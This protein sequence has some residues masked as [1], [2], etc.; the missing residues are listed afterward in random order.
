MQRPSQRQRP[1]LKLTPGCTT[2]PMDI[3][4]LDILISPP[5][6]ILMAIMAS[7]TPTSTIMARGRLS[8]RL[9]LTL[10]L[11][12]GCSMVTMDSMEVTMAMDT[13]I[14]WHIIWQA[15]ETTWGPLFLVQDSLLERLGIWWWE[16]K[17]YKAL[18]NLNVEN[19]F[20]LNKQK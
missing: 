8:Q 1:T 16:S 10:R 5:T 9:R 18:N 11:T 15:A 3:G 17:F 12:P 20:W 19:H 6:L 4:L 2:P 13:T 14:L 7:T